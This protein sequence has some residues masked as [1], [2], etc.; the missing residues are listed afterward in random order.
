ML[1]DASRAAAANGTLEE[2]PIDKRAASAAGYVIEKRRGREEER[3]SKKPFVPP[4]SLPLHPL[5]SLTLFFFLCFGSFHPTM[6][7]LPNALT[8]GLSPRHTRRHERREST[9]CAEFGF[10]FF[11][12]PF[13]PLHSICSVPNT[14]SFRALSLTLNHFV[15]VRTPSGPHTTALHFRLI[16]NDLPS[17]FTLPLILAYRVPHTVDCVIGRVPRQCGLSQRWNVAFF[18]DGRSP[19]TQTPPGRLI[20]SLCASALPPSRHIMC[21]CVPIHN[22]VF[23]LL[24]N[25]THMHAPNYH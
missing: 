4:L 16:A 12:R 1:G 20:A 21:V 9:F 24:L 15:S 3:G 6:A 19:K 25:H 5:A 18:L 13:S 22:W 11:D 7:R 17:V 2:V 10:F 8:R 23:H 14:P